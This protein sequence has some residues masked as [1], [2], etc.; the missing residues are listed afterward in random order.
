M[1]KKIICVIANGYAEEMMA[2]M[3]MKQMQQDLKKQNI[4]N[5]YQFIGGSLV[6]S[7]KW[8]HEKHFPTFYSGGM[9]PSGGFPT[10]SWQGFFQDLMAGVFGTPFK[11]M[12]FIN[13]WARYNLDMVIVVGDFLLM[14]TALPIFK[15]KIP[16]IF[17]P[18]AKSNYIQAHY[19]VEKYFIKKYAMISYPR[20]QITKNDFIDYGINAQYFGNLMQDLLDH[21]SP[22]IISNEPIIAL[23]PGSRKESYGNFQMMLNVIDGVSANIHWAFVQAG[24]LSSE[25]FTEIFN[26]NN[27]TNNN[28]ILKENVA[29][30][31]WEKNGKHVFVYPS[32]RFDSVALS[33]EFALSLAGTVGDQIVGLGKPIISFKGTGPQSSIQRM[34]EYEKLLGEA[35]I[36]E[37]NYPK[38]VIKKI[39]ELL[40]DPQERQRLGQIGLEHMGQIGATQKIAQDIIDRFRK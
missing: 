4:D 21:S 16:L 6:S 39:K 24:S 10:R 1:N 32:N 35:F 29:I 34:N 7:G 20:D 25:K 2:S 19:K 17:I 31:C 33:C 36:Y 22:K 13:D 28:W 11:L 8:F 40:N 9:S 30:S 12:N 18:T 3:L 23:L 14:M 27:W 38:G 37:R 26:N 5:Q 15:K